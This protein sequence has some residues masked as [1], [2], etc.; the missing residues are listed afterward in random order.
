MSCYAQNAYSPKIKLITIAQTTD[1]VSA[2][3]VVTMSN[4]IDQNTYYTIK[5]PSIW[6][7]CCDTV[8]FQYF[9]KA[10]SEAMGC[11]FCDFSYTEECGCTTN[12]IAKGNG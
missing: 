10:H 1:S 3:N 2:E 11:Y 7:G 6:R 8:Q 12:A 4:V 5:E 9:C